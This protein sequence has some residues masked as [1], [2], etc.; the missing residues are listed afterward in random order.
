[1]S[2]KTINATYMTDEVK[3]VE[4]TTVEETQEQKPT[5]STSGEDAAKQ[6]TEQPS[7]EVQEDA[8][9]YEALYKEEK[10]RREKA[11]HK[12]VK[13]RAKTLDEEQEESETDEKE[14]L[15]SY[16]DKRLNE[17]K[18][19]SLESQ[20]E[21]EINKV[22]SNEAEKKLI[23]LHLEENNFAGTITDQV[24][25]AKALANYKKVTQANKELAKAA[26]VKPSGEESS[27]YKPSQPKRVSD[28][29]AEDIAF[30]KKRGVY[31]KYMEKYGK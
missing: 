14:D 6:T 1:M 3:P 2:A 11:E 13:M 29:T 7:Q 30:L 18:I 23:R 10:E 15:K 8:V 9:D 31:E 22:S 19:V 25:K 5:E 20:Y 17:I 24:L 27:S 26:E 28:L 16:V 12:I 4:E 21:A